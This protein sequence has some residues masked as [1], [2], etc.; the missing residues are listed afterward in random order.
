MTAII[1]ASG[2]D[3]ISIPIGIRI[4]AKKKMYSAYVLQSDRNGGYY[5][6][7]T[8]DIS[9]RL[10]AHNKGYSTYTKRNGPFKLKYQEDYKTLSE[11]KKREYYLKSL[12]SRKAIEKLIQ[13]AFV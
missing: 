7:S 10:I 4:R 6:G 8:K 11:A 9:K 12:K 3:L 2:A 5:I 13:G 1:G